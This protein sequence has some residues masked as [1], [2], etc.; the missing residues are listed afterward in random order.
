MTVSSTTDL[1]FSLF[2]KTK[3][4]FLGYSDEQLICMIKISQAMG[5]C[6]DDQD[7]PTDYVLTSISY[8]MDPIFSQL[9]LIEAILK[10]IGISSFHKIKCVLMSSS[11]YIHA[12]IT[13]KPFYECDQFNF[14]YQSVIGKLNY[15]AQTSRPDIV[16]AVHHLD[17]YS[18]DPC[19][20]HGIAMM[21]FNMYL[22]Y[23]KPIGIK[24]KI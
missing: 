2:M 21:S 7:H 5:L 3:G 4:I 13:S 1:S 15:L 22:N 24:V 20:D 11:K 6:I 12:R 10:D 16:F 17:R 18:A 8:L 14:N 19:K 9:A 23:T